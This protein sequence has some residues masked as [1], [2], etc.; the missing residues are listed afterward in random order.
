MT[1]FKREP[2]K[3]D[4]HDFLKMVS[5]FADLPDKD[6]EYL[7]QVSAEEHLEADKILFTEG[8]AGD[9]AYVIMSGEVEIFKESDG[10]QVLLATRHAGEVIGEMS[11]LD[12]APR[13]ASGRTR[14]DSRLLAISHENL[15]HLLD[16]S[17][18]AARVILS[19]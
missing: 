10:R 7:C 17:P 14:T 4:M 19:T 3:R 1:A 2:V 11:L 9:K 13:F 16:A 15:D 6:L 8:D 12:Q 5:L 18:S